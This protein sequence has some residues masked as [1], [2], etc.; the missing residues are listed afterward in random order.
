MLFFNKNTSLF[1]PEITIVI[2]S[3]LL[4]FPWEFLQI[5]FFKNFSNTPHIEGI[6]I[7]FQAALGDSVITLFA[8]WG[9][10]Y[11]SKNR[12]WILKP[13]LQNL[14]V[15]I[16]I[17]IFITIVFEWIATDILDRWQYADI[18]PRLPLLG[19]GFL[20]ILQWL[21]LPPVILF[22]TRRHMLAKS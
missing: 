3:F 8:F 20:P 18:M 6:K 17:G 1:F 10:A 4:N 2:F 11:I 16:L 19:T 15:Y 14:F 5:P 7:C 21:I 22:L 12:F 9:A 13:N